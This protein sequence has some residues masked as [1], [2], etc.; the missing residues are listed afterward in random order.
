MILLR[1]DTRKAFIKKK[2]TFGILAGEQSWMGILIEL[3]FSRV[4]AI[5][6]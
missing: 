1:P 3:P 2:R 6:R 5:L 4:A